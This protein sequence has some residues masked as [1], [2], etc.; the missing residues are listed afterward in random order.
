[1]KCQRMTLY[2]FNL[3]NNQKYRHEPGLY[4]FG[5]LGAHNFPFLVYITHNNFFIVKRYELENILK[6]IRMIFKKIHFEEIEKIELLE[7]LS[8]FLIKRIKKLENFSFKGNIIL[9][10]KL[11]KKRSKKSMMKNRLR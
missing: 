8:D 4:R 6:R 3:S 9:G 7:N 10:N 5:L 11:N 1:M 2:K